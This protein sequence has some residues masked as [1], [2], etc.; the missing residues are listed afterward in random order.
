MSGEQGI[1]LVTGTSSG[2]GLATSVHLAANGYRVFAGMRNLAKAQ[3]LESAAADLPLTV[4][5]MDVTD[6]ASV[7]SAFAAAESAGPVDV[8]V[9]NAGIGGATPVE[10]TT[11]EEHQAMF[12][13]N[14]FGAM[15]CIR[16][17]LPS[18]RE[19]RSGCIVN[20]TSMEGLFA[21][22]NQVAYSASK[23]ALE[24]AGEVLAHEVVRFGVR[25]V[26][27]EPG[28]IMTNIFENSA[29]MT[30]YDKHS[31]YRD[32]MRRNA[33]MFSAGFRAGVSP[34]RVAASILEAIETDDYRLRWPVGEDALG[35]LNGR[36]AMTDEQ[37]VELGGD[38]SDED[39]NALYAH[40]FGIELQ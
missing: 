14:Y 13:T 37:Y 35:L 17:A 21:M 39:Y 40:H 10:D 38:L 12:D 3:K 25:V 34:E 9:N 32:V 31:P 29:P 1:A 23:W 5:Q 4:V 26:N 33:K 18:M 7:A 28:V 2:I 6:D 19:R 15:R 22:P 8:L 11:I 16:R 30:R 20:V 24:C 27:V 36:R